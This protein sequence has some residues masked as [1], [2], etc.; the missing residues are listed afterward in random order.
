MIGIHT[1]N[2]SRQDIIGNIADNL[3]SIFNNFA[4]WVWL[5]FLAKGG[6]WVGWCTSIRRSAGIYAAGFGIPAKNYGRTLTKCLYF[7]HVE[8]NGMFQ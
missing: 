4:K 5:Y 3:E 6:S 7:R 1:D 2:H 8:P